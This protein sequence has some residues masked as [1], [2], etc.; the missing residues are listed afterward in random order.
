MRIYLLRHGEIAT[1]GRMIGQTDVQL[2]DLGREQYHTIAQYLQSQNLEMVYHSPLHRCSES[3]QIIHQHCN[4]PTRVESL[5]TE[6]NLGLWDGMNKSDIQQ[7]YSKEFAERAANWAH[8]R[9]PQGESFSDLQ[10]R[11][12][13]G[14]EKCITNHHHKRIAIVS[15]AGVNRTLL[16][17]IHGIPLAD[18]FSIE[19]NYGC[20]NILEID[21][22]KHVVVMENCSASG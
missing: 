3:A 14:F 11:A 10:Q 16:A 12:W 8:F 13:Q 21:T 4:I 19:Q 22:G 15:H 20:I 18:I 5:L 7:R 17:Q 1:Q 2:T 9:P 6:I